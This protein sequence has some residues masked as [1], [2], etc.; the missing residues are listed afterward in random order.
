MDGERLV[1]PF[2]ERRGGAGVRGVE[3]GSECLE[4]FERPG[5]VVESPRC[6]QSFAEGGAVAVG[7]VVQHVAF[8]MH[9]MPMSA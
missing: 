6:A 1:Q 7:E 8:F 3:S 5:V 4:P 2:P 9:V